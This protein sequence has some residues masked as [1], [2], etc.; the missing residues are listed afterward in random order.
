[1]ATAYVTIVGERVYVDNTDKVATTTNLTH[2]GGGASHTTKV[3]GAFMTGSDTNG[4]QMNNVK[5]EF[6]AHAS[7]TPTGVTV[8]LH[9]DNNE[10]PGTLVDTLCK[11]P[12]CPDSYTGDTAGGEVIFTKEAGILLDPGAKYWVVVTGSAGLLNTTGDHGQTGATGWSIQNGIIMD[13]S[14]AVQDNT[15][16]REDASRS[17]MM[18]VSGIPRGGVIVDTDSNIAG[19]QTAL[20]VNENSSSTYRVRLD[21]PPPKDTKVEV[22]SANRSIAT[23]VRYSDDG[24]AT[25]TLTFTKT[26]WWMPQDVKVHGG[27]VNGDLGTTIR[28]SASGDSFKDPASLPSV[29]VSVND[30]ISDVTLLDNIGNTTADRLFSP[31]SGTSTN[32]IAQR[33]T[34]GPDEYSLNYIQVDFAAASQG[35]EVRVCAADSAAGKATG[36]DCSQYSGTMTPSAGLHTY[37][38]ESENILSAGKSYYVVVCGDSGDISVHLTDDT[39]EDP[40]LGW[41]LGDSHVTG[42]DD[43]SNANPRID[44]WPPGSGIAKVKL[45]GYRIDTTP[46]PTP[47]PSPT[48]T[49]TSTPTPTVT[50]TPTATP[51]PGTPTAT[52]TPGTPTPGT[53]TPGTPTVTPTPTA[54]AAPIAGV[55]PSG[56]RVAARTQTTATI[57]WIPGA[58]AA[59]YIAIASI[60]GESVGLWKTS[61]RLDGAARSYTFTGLRQKAYTYYVYVLDTSGNILRA[62]DGSLRSISVMGS[63]PPALD[64]TPSGL[65]VVRSGSTAIVRWT[66][67]ADAAKQYVAAMIT[68]DQ[69]SL[70]LVGPLGATVNSQ[71]FTGLKQGVYTYHILAFDAYGNYSAPDGSFYYAWKTE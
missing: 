6:G 31:E 28:H 4:Y 52:P 12:D 9:R 35:V 11:L 14:T 54:T 33:F 29:S 36:S 2:P 21:S 46:A 15:V 48:E 49:P 44:R 42:D 60:P 25:T 13:T 45:I 55:V 63:G 62:P 7:N 43:A 61:D 65:S 40:A 10:R 1:M 16:W 59:G 27:F 53:P 22:V 34:V 18:Q 26:D 24:V 71:A 38:L 20:R 66:P 37:E 51:T 69:S 39:N 50:G 67:G 32:T 68:G 3:A 56:L 17:L 5:L 57:S 30:P 41:S 8:G 19:A 70:Q 47:T 58:D 23:A 64:V